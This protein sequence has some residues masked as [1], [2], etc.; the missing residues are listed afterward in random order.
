[1]LLIRQSPSL[2]GDKKPSRNAK[3]WAKVAGL[4]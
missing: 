2:G 1:V 3:P 4:S